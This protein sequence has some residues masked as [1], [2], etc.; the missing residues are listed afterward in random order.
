ME[1]VFVVFS[2]HVFAFGDR[3]LLFN[4]R[5]IAIA[6]QFFFLSWN[7]CATRTA[8]TSNIHKI[9]YIY[10]LKYVI[11]YNGIDFILCVTC[12]YLIYQKRPH[13]MQIIFNPTKR[14]TFYNMTDCRSADLHVAVFCQANNK[15]IA[16]IST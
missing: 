3:L 11:S 7:L 16:I 1:S 6:V 12:E 10:K 5:M 14:L 8:R 2:L 4:F 13:R 9:K 15:H